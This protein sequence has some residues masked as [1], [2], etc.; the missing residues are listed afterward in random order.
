MYVDGANGVAG[1]GSDLLNAA[2]GLVQQELQSP[3]S[4]ASRNLQRTIAQRVVKAAKDENI[5]QELGQKIGC[6][7]A[8]AIEDEIPKFPI[9]GSEPDYGK[10]PKPAKGASGLGAFINL[11]DMFQP[12]MA[13][14]ERTAKEIAQPRIEARLKPW[15]I[16]LPLVG[17]G[18][19]LGV[20]WWF[21]KR[22]RK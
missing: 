2:K 22:K 12:V 4:A 18:V 17:L 11:E 5:G 3:S 1:W 16:G 19:G 8:D 15:F 13:D 7:F 20:G 14:A 6:A 9:F 10:C 21:W